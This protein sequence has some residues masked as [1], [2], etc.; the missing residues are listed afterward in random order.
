M[1]VGDERATKDFV[2][3]LTERVN[4]LEE[5]NKRL[6]EEDHA[7]AAAMANDRVMA[8]EAENQQLRM[9]LQAIAL[10]MRP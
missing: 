7:R 9:R 3:S 5:E 1:I 4:K 10:V 2:A 6:A 8:L